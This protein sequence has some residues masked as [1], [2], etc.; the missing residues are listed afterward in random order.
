LDSKVNTS[1]QIPTCFYEKIQVVYLLP[2][3]SN[4]YDL[5]S[6]KNGGRLYVRESNDGIEILAKSGKKKSNQQFLINRLNEIY[7]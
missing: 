6:S 4:P 1:F 5:E 7:G 3:F 2:E